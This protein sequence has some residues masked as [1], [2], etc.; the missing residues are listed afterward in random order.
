VNVSRAQPRHPSARLPAASDKTTLRC[1]SAEIASRQD[2]PDIVYRELIA[3]GSPIPMSSRTHRIE[4][5]AGGLDGDGWLRRCDFA[6]AIH[7]IDRC[8]QDFYVSRSGERA[9]WG[10]SRPSYL[11]GRRSSGHVSVRCFFGCSGAPHR[12]GS[13]SRKR[14]LWL[15][16]GSPWERKRRRTASPP[17]T[18]GSRQRQN[19][20][21]RTVHSATALPTRWHYIAPAVSTPALPPP[22]G[23]N[24]ERQ[25]KH[26]EGQSMQPR[27]G[28]Q[29]NRK[30]Q[31][32]DGDI[33]ES[34]SVVA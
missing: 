27:R 5:S 15:L 17:S 6:D 18:D 33:T 7:R 31:E 4:S 25:S 11:N 26:R 16:W 21:R 8:H 1:E 12:S 13:A 3:I 22:S 30:A 29:T 20:I 10:V 9:V 19:N 28:T 14:L 34:A 32:N 23:C 24:K 2:A